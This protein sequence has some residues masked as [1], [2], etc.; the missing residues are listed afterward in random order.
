MTRSLCL[1]LLA[2]APAFASGPPELI[3]KLNKTVSLKEPLDAAL[4]LVLTE[5]AEQHGLTGKVILDARA[6]K[7]AGVEDVRAAMVKL[8][9]LADVKLA[10]LLA[11]ILKQVDGCYLVKDTH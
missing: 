9:K 7:A 1:L 4:D 5:L 10:T 2:T 3:T 8:D 11:A 6:F